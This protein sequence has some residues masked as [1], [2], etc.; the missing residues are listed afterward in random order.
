MNHQVDSEIL[1]YQC[2]AKFKISTQTATLEVR[3]PE[4]GHTM[5]FDN[6]ETTV[7]GRLMSPPPKRDLPIDI[8]SDDYKILDV[9]GQGGMGTV[10]KAR[11]ISLNRLV[12]VKILPTQLADD[13]QFLS[14]FQ[15]EAATLATLD[16]PYV[17]QVIGKG[18]DQGFYY[19]VMEFVNGRDLAQI[20]KEEEPSYEDKLRYLLDICRGLEYAHDQGVIHRDIKPANIL[21]KHSGEVK[22]TDFGLARIA[23]GANQHVTELTVTEMVMGTV[24]YMAPEQKSDSKRVDHR[25]DIYSLGV[26]IYEIFTGREPSGRFALPTEIDKSLDPRLDYLVDKALQSEPDD[27]FDSIS[28][29]IEV[30]EAMVR[31]DDQTVAL[32]RGYRQTRST[33]SHLKQTASIALA[34][35]LSAI[36]VYFVFLPDRKNTKGL[37]KG[38]QKG[39]TRTGKEEKQAP[40][41]F[42][43]ALNK[44]LLEAQ[45]Q[46]E[47]TANEQVYQNWAKER[48]EKKK[49]AQ[50]WILIQ[51]GALVGSYKSREE[52]MKVAREKSPNSLHRYLFLSG[53]DDGKVAASPL[54]MVAT[55]ANEKSRWQQVG[56]EF[57]SQF[58]VESSWTEGKLVW[59]RGKRKHTWQAVAPPPISLSLGSDRGDRQDL[60]FYPA[61]PHL[62]VPLLIR[63]GTAK[64]LNLYRYSIPG[65]ANVFSGSMYAKATRVWCQVQIPSLEID[66]WVA[67][68]VAPRKFI[69]TINKHWGREKPLFVNKKFTRPTTHLSPAQLNIKR[70]IERQMSAAKFKYLDG[71]LTAAR[72]YLDSVLK[73][74]YHHG[75]ARL[76]R[77]M[78]WLAHNRPHMAE[79]DI[80]IVL[81][82]KGR[83]D[84]KTV[85]RAYAVYSL[86]QE[87]M[88]RSMAMARSWRARANLYDPGYQSF[89]DD[90]ISHLKDLKRRGAISKMPNISAKLSFRRRKIKRK[91]K[92]SYRNP[93]NRRYDRKR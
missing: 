35:C 82:R 34:A 76:Y 51:Q 70:S 31:G 91:F 41:L 36:L 1:C 33:T 55:E 2:G 86:V 17:V 85:G 90:Y 67:A 56:R 59:K 12:A 87:A 48:E 27:R 58:A 18:N 79:S 69:Q 74:N 37:P 9:L 92:K 26:M 20:L 25:A 46:M 8:L 73:K 88:G 81:F 84:K 39:E 23:A 28:K 68:T 6:L 61:Y 7:E 78:I 24:K 71:D 32:P 38:K 47:A 75:E 83:P 54:Q 63:E 40:P 77:A 57:L 50:E 66:H 80:R 60:P 5:E 10:Y 43:Q 89:I 14:R 53:R 42:V 72:R 22:I 13:D 4:C 3:C 30:L 11:Q 21:V 44:I 16:S 93:K 19:F 45:F 64:K 52:A 62:K 15:R 49:E 29:V 65:T